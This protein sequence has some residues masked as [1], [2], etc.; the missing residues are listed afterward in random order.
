MSFDIQG[1]GSAQG[2]ARV[3]PA[4]AVQAASTGRAEHLDEAVDVRTMPSSPPPEVLDAVR[5]AAGAYD[6]LRASGRQVQFG[7]DQTTGRLSVQLQDLQGNTMSSVTPSQ[8]LAIA[9]GETH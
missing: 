4:R 1:V 7:V 6:R 8:V 2:P 9:D 3:G 5:N